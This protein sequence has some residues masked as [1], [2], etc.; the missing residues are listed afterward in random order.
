MLLGVAD[1]V[2]VILYVFAIFFL[3]SAKSVKIAASTVRAYCSSQGTSWIHAR[4][5]SVGMP[6]TVRAVMGSQR[7]RASREPSL[8]RIL[9]KASRPH[10][11]GTPHAVPRPTT[12]RAP[13]GIHVARRPLGYSF[14]NTAAAVEIR[15]IPSVKALAFKPQACRQGRDRITGDPTND[16]GER[17]KAKTRTKTRPFSCPHYVGPTH[18]P[19]TRDATTTAVTDHDQVPHI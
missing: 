14:G 10:I 15:L 2:I 19:H 17:K 11:G 3:T 1:A 8:L 5:S 12:L 16:D 4:V 13:P 18:R 7:K 9:A 6:I